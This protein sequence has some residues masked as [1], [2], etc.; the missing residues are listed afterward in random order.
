M[1]NNSEPVVT[2]SPEF[3]AL[4]RQW[5]DHLRNHQLESDERIKDYVGALESFR[6]WAMERRFGN[7]RAWHVKGW[8]RYLSRDA[9]VRI[10]PGNPWIIRKGFTP[11]MMN[12]HLSAVLHFY[13]FMISQTKSR[14]NGNPVF[15][16][17]RIH[18]EDPA[19]DC[20]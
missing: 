14:M 3:Y 10:Q 7:I 18:L 6:S 17:K 4:V 20:A 2:T 11:R 16:V 13:R 8:L 1:L 12:L 19:Y 5:R 15:D 9:P